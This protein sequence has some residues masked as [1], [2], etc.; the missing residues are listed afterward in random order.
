MPRIT[1]KQ[2]EEQKKKEELIKKWN[3]FT[4]EHLKICIDSTYDCITSYNNS[5]DLCYKRINQEYEAERNKEKINY[6]E[7]QIKELEEE[8]KIIEDIYIKRF[9][10]KPESLY[11]PKVIEQN[12]NYIN[13]ILIKDLII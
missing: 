6:L 9:G 12:I 4:E 10:Y 13:N 3:S 11:D 8:L 7:K 5:I 1:K 2:I